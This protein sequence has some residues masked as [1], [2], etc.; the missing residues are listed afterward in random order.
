MGILQITEES[1]LLTI[2]QTCVIR[3]VGCSGIG[4]GYH[5]AYDAIRNK[6]GVPSVSLIRDACMEGFSSRGTVRGCDIYIY[7]MPWLHNPSCPRE[8]IPAHYLVYPKVAIA[9]ARGLGG[10]Q[11]VMAPVYIVCKDIIIDEETTCEHIINIFEYDG[12]N[13]DIKKTYL[14]NY[15][16][17]DPETVCRINGYPDAETAIRA[18]LRAYCDPIQ[19]EDSDQEIF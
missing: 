5:E 3:G 18:Y 16:P 17:T 6:Y 10:L 8:Y 12:E 2:G 13:V 1:S 11:H 4:H 19:T 15:Q 14:H 9:Y 7:K